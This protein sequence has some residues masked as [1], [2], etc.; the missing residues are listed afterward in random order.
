M[1]QAAK[2][3][4]GWGNSG[5]PGEFLYAKS[6]RLRAEVRHTLPEHKIWLIASIISYV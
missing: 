3:R 1:A 4:K 2:A 6:N 5:E